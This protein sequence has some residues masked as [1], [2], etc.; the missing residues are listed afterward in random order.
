VARVD[1]R[2][3]HVQ[4]L[5]DRF[6]LGLVES[7]GFQKQPIMRDILTKDKGA[8]A[9]TAWQRTRDCELARDLNDRRVARADFAAGHRPRLFVLRCGRQIFGYYSERKAARLDPIEALRYA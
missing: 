3:F 6:S 5:L 1:F 8:V 9:L 2:P 7:P 4:K